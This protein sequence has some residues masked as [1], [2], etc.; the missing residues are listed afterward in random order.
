METTKKEELAI[1]KRLSD[2]KCN[3]IGENGKLLSEQW[4]DWIDYFHEGFAI[5]RRKDYLNNFI[6]KQGKLLSEEWFSW[7]NDFK[8]GLAVG[9]RTNG[10]Y[11]KIDKQ[12][13]ILVVSEKIKS[14]R[15]GNEKSEINL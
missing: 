10:E 12:G 1:V 5:V 9:Q 2:G 8:D 11:F 6:D 13:K 3:L 14:K 15:N 4:F 7:V